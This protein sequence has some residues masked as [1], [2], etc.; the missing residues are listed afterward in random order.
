IEPS[1]AALFYSL[2]RE[3]RRALRAQGDG[4]RLDGESVSR[5]GA[6]LAAAIAARPESWSPGALL[7]P[8]VQDLALPVAAYVG[9]PG[10]LGHHPQPPERRVRVGAPATPFVR[11]ISCTL[12]DPE[13][14]V[15]L[16]KLG[17]GLE[18]W[19][20]ARGAIEPDRAGSEEP[21]VIFKMRSIADA[22]ARELE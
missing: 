13:C 7:R 5:T 9:G 10:R 8:I 12:V 15:S 19:L 11:R 4:F 21:D 6:E 16:A 2:E 18:R 14:R 17:V 3:G 1:G 22:A 20:R